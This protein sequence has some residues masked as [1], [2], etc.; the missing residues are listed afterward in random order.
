MDLF[1]EDFYKKSNV[2]LLQEKAN[3]TK[4]RKVIELSTSERRA[5]EKFCEE[6]IDLYQNI[7]EKIKNK[8]ELSTRNS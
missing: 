3:V 5:I 7:K 2:R 1:I 6:D 4:S 8:N